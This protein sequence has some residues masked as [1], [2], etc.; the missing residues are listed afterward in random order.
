MAAS[1][2]AS[3]VIPLFSSRASISNISD[4]YWGTLLLEDYETTRRYLQTRW[5]KDDLILSNHAVSY[6]CSPIFLQKTR[7]LRHSREYP[8]L[9]H[10]RNLRRRPDARKNASYSKPRRRTGR[11]RPDHQPESQAQYPHRLPHPG[12]YYTC[13]DGADRCCPAL[14]QCRPEVHSSRPVPGCP[15]GRGKRS[16]D[17]GCRATR[18]PTLH[19]WA[20]DR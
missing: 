20:G 16:A 18:A 10:S 9:H 17:R 3:R 5:T 2:I 6:R 15:R 8:D 12:H 19:P 14:Y 4:M 11:D 7:I 1:T 13:D